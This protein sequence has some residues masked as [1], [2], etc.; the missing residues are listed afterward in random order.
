MENR[1]LNKMCNGFSL[2]IRNDKGHGCL[3]NPWKLPRICYHWLSRISAK[4][5][6]QWDG[7]DN[8]QDWVAVVNGNI[9]FTLLGGA[10]QTRPTEMPHMY[11]LSYLPTNNNDT[12]GHILEKCPAIRMS[13]L[14][15]SD[16][17][18]LEYDNTQMSWKCRAFQNTINKS[19]L[20]TFQYN[21]HLKE[22]CQN[23]STFV[24]N[25]P[26]WCSIIRSISWMVRVYW[27]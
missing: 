26:E 13:F 4:Y 19:K 7:K 6:H 18:P 24:L 27:V 17:Q 20:F 12:G 21:E 22:G 14:H 25:L 10:G 16:F 8:L 5:Q 1:T 23:T 11:F 9:C 15:I 3:D 2:L